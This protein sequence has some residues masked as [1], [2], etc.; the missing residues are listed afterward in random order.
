MAKIEESLGLDAK[1]I[2][3]CVSEVS[4]VPRTPSCPW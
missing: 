3:P 2:S 4:K 1:L